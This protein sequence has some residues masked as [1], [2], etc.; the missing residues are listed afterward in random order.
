MRRT[1]SM[2]SYYTYPVLES[3]IRIKAISEGYDPTIGIMH[4]GSDGSSKIHIR[5]YWSRN[6]RRLIERCWISSKVRSLI[7]PTLSFAST[8]FAG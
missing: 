4:E 5:I 3:E 1:R 7:Q 2:R 8:T 6:D